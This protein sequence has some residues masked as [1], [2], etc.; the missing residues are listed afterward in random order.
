MYLENL[1]KNKIHKTKKFLFKSLIDD[2]LKNFRLNKSA[3]TRSAVK[4]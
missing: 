1:N 4:I 2:Y 3:L